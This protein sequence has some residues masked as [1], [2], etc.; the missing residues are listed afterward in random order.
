[1]LKFFFNSPTT[2]PQTLIGASP[3]AP[4]HFYLWV[5]GS[6]TLLSTTILLTPTDR[7]TDGQ[8]DRQTDRHG[9][10]NILIFSKYTQNRMENP[11]MRTRR[12][13]KE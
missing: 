5:G 7:R 13:G 12:A 6:H 3:R 1:M 10:T 8:T 9:Q 2:P 11:K 4:L